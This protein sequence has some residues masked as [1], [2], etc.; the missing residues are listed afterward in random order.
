VP[1]FRLGKKNARHDPRT[2]R[3]ADYRTGTLTAPAQ[4]HWGHGLPFTML[5][6]DNAGDCV[7]A[8]YAHHVQV[9]CDRAGHPFTPT[10]AE[11]LGAYSAITGYNPADPSTDQGTDMLT[12]CNY[13]RSTGMAGHEITAFL[14]VPPRQQGLVKESV[15]F[16][17][18]LY[19]GV[20][21]PLSA[22][23]Q[24]G[25]IWK[26]VTGP[27]AAAGSW[28]GHCIA[29]TG[30]DENIL[31]VCT[32]GRLQAMEWDFL[33]TYGDEAFVLLSKDWQET[34]GT[35]PSGLAWGALQA[36]LANL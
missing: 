4:A 18:G 28:G 1:D 21:L 3:L 9:W 22:Q 19:L 27:D 16:Y 26:V 29:V 13:W 31:W 20:Q 15:A 25:D 32:W 8:G 36:D 2:L 6:N 24:V 30:Y 7:E 33:A 35:S 23:A 11:A 5:G 12:A 34:S 17:G 10:D 14:S